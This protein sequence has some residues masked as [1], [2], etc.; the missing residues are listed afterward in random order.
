MNPPPPSA[1]TLYVSSLAYPASVGEYDATTGAVINA[2]FISGLQDFEPYGLALSGNNL[3]VANNY[4]GTVG[5]YNATTG[6]A[7]AGFSLGGLNSPYGLA[8]SGN[9]LYVSSANNNTVGEYD[10]TTGAV[11]NASFIIGLSQPNGTPVA[12]TL[13]EPLGLAISTDG[14]DLYVVNE[15]GAPAGVDQ[16][17]YGAGTVSEYDATTGKAVPGFTDPSYFAGDLSGPIDVAVFG[18]DLYVSGYHNVSEYDA[19]T[20]DPIPGFADLSGSGV[21][22]TFIVAS[23]SSQDPAPDAAVPEPSTWASGIA[24]LGGLLLLGRR[25]RA[26]EKLLALDRLPKSVPFLD[27][28][29]RQPVPGGAAGALFPAQ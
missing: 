21:A 27:P 5:A 23:D 16:G 24:A 15:Y 10:A 9:N 18:N 20:G 17:E 12:G 7:I 28:I 22:P 6:E 4:G 25:S 26:R 13:S 19:T 1:Q 2:S 29:R 8:V 14:N 11:I 3:Y